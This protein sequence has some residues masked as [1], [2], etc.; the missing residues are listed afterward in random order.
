ML[1]GDMS[2]YRPLIEERLRN[3][4]APAN[5]D[6]QGPF[7]RGSLLFPELSE[8]PVPWLAP[9]DGPPSA[10]YTRRAVQEIAAAMIGPA[11]RPGAEGPIPAAFTYFGQ[12]VFH[13]MVFSRI[14]GIPQ[15]AGG[16]FHFRNAASQGLDLSG[17]YGRGPQVDGHLYDRPG[18]GGAACRFP[19]GLP[20][21]KDHE[22]NRMPV[23]AGR[24]LPR[25]DMSGLFVDVQGRRQP[26]HPLVGDPRN[27]D[28]VVLSQLQATL[29]GIHN[30]LVGVQLR[31]GDCRAEEAYDRA[32][33]F[34]ISAYRK[35]V[36]HD[37]MS[38]VLDD[39]I[40]AYFFAGA[41]PAD[42]HLGELSGL[43]LEFTFG[44]SRFAH[45]MV[46]Q[47]YTVNDSFAEQAGPLNE[48][49][50]RSSL[51]PDGNVPLEVNWVVDWKRF[52]AG[53]DPTIVQHAR[54]IS[55]F[56]A[57]DLSSDLSP[58]LATDLAGNVLPVSFMDNWRCYELGLPSG[59]AVAETLAGRLPHGIAVEVLRDDAMLPT[60]ACTTLFPYNA[61]KLKGALKAAR[62]FL[63]DTPLSY[64]ILQEASA[65]GEN[66]SHLG[67][68]GSY[69]V[70]AT[71]VAS[72]YSTAD[73]NFP[74]GSKV[75]V[76]TGTLADLLALE[77]PVA[78]P[79]DKLKRMLDNSV[80][81]T[82]GRA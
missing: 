10:D 14:F 24:D 32:R 7:S 71:V 44:A 55:P 40:W 77:D 36:V 52:V 21:V 17:L 12:F 58:G 15:S 27:D 70:G 39:R 72:L 26:Y 22:G 30:R 16:G 25:L 9:G 18:D 69:I 37:Y 74:S 6:D 20:C 38:R 50:S 65:L 1:H 45:S 57:S 54:R 5:D 11:D 81:I 8:H 66:G 73:T 59:Q 23:C 64:Y 34:L 76:A 68:V 53:D 51:R 13:D 3:R 56:L 35:V 2:S 60:Q 29:M 31:A 62:G 19:V 78:N 46:R 4:G 43:P 61:A 82:G 47:F 75:P 63:S 49:L 80:Q 28:N 33:T 42:A 67:P 48:V 79:D 41:P